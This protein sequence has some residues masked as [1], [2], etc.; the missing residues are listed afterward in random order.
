V[1]GGRQVDDVVARLVG[2]QG[3]QGADWPDAITRAPSQVV[4]ASPN[5]R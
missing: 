3:E 1:I 5:T 2:Q 4:I